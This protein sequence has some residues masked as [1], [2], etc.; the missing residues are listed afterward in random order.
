M[1]YK[2]E[3]VVSKNGAVGYALK[4]VDPTNDGTFEIDCPYIEHRSYESLF[5][6][7]LN[8][9]RRQQRKPAECQ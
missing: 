1:K 9:T 7:V 8:E 6:K 4:I 2:C 3:K 5:K